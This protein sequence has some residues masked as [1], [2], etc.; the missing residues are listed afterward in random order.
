MS[1]KM[2]ALL[3]LLCFLTLTHE[4]NLQI[5]DFV[6]TSD[7]SSAA[8]VIDFSYYLTKYNITVMIKKPLKKVMVMEDSSHISSVKFN[9][10]IFQ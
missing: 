4:Y 9:P 1:L 5:T 2:E 3:I 8:E 6:L 7:D 10:I